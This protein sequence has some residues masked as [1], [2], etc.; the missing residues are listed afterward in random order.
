M[1]QLELLSNE[2]L[3][4]LFEYLNTHHLLQAFFGFNDR[5]NQLLYTHFRDHQLNF[6]SISKDNFDLIC[7]QYLPSTIDQV[8]SLYLSNKET[9]DLPEL[10]FS[11]GFTLDRFINLRS[12]SLYNIRFLHQ[13]NGI[14]YQCRYLPHLIHLNIIKCPVFE[15]REYILVE[16]INNI[17]SI[18]TLTHCNLNGI[19]RSEQWVCRITSVSTSIKYLSIEKSQCE[20]SSLS[21]LLKCTPYLKKLSTVVRCSKSDECLDCVIPSMKSLK[22]DFRGSADLLK[23]IF[24]TMPNL[25]HLTIDIS[26]MYLDGHAWEHIINNY[27]PKIK[28]F[29]LKMKFQFE[30]NSDSMV[31]NVDK[32]LM[33]FQTTFWLEEYRWFVRCHWDPSDTLRSTI[34]YTLPYAFNEY[35]YSNGFYS[36]STCLNEK[37]YWTYD[38]VDMITLNNNRK[39]SVDTH[40]VPVSHFPNIR[41]A[42]INF[43]LNEYF[44][45][46]FPSF[47]RLT[48]LHIHVDTNPNYDQLQMLINQASFLYSLRFCP[49]Q[50]SRYELFQLSSKSIRR[51]E[52]PYTPSTRSN[53][54]SN[55]DC[56]NLI[57]SPLGIQ[58]EVLSICFENRIDILNLIQ[59]M[60]NLR[61]LVFKS[62]DDNEFFR[63]VTPGGDEFVQ[64]LKNHL[65]SSHSI[66]R[67]PRLFAIRIWID[68]Q[69]H[70]IKT[71][72]HQN[73]FSWFLPLIKRFFS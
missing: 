64:W 18:P 38:S 12:L 11:R 17:W 52:F 4:E 41:H 50:K 63:S 28:M 14:I 60:S 55:E 71:S 66:I 43:P 32:L 57:H 3:L 19:Q 45:L 31:E 70:N 36:K 61:L 58:C 2:L 46:L 16:S 67:D 47:H 23:S 73:K 44:S 1:I 6:H 56:Y 9:S 68:R 5:F 33:T 24:Q 51:L 15:L 8:H 42:E 54:F 22:L 25:C 72:E 37:D 53:N 27:L 40:T 65:S 20:L 30:Q 49:A 62:E 59:K 35:S 34:I 10:L 39:T 29:R 48:S 26:Q 21:H 13:F 7:Q 69:N